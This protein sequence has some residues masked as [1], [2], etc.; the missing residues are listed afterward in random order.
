MGNPV[1][2]RTFNPLPDPRLM[3]LLAIGGP[4]CDLHLAADQLQPAGVRLVCGLLVNLCAV[5]G[6][7]PRVRSNLRSNSKN[8]LKLHNGLASAGRFAVL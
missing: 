1:E 3:P 2:T 6:T 4:Y 8:G 7:A 5:A